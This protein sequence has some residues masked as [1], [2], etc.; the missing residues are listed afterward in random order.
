MTRKVRRLGIKNHTRTSLLIISIGI[1]SE[2]GSPAP[3]SQPET[4][5]TKPFNAEPASGE[6]SSMALTRSMKGK[7]K[8]VD[9]DALM[10]KDDFEYGRKAALLEP[11]EK[12]EEGFALWESGSDKGDDA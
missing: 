12:A 5:K 10:R 11:I 3:A 7:G 9:I 1:A 4:P 2:L 6:S 8:E